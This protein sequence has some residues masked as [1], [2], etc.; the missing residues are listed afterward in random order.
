MYVNQDEELLETINEKERRFQA[1]ME[2][3]REAI[4]RIDLQPPLRIN[5]SKDRMAESIFH[6]TTITEA[7]D[8]M[9]KMYGYTEGRQIIV[10][11]LSDFMHATSQENIAAVQ[12]LVREKFLVQDVITHERKADGTTGIFLNN[13]TPTFK[14]G[15][16]VYFW[17]SSLEITEL[18]ALQEDIKKTN[19]ELKKQKQA[20]EEKIL[21]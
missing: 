16:L 5:T 6:H 14:A 8:A 9:A 10:R 11:P 1:Y 13:T 12:E 3:T 19:W 7:N 17:G 15:A 20:L 2:N 4:W 21:P 18:F